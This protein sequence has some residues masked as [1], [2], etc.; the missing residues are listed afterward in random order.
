MFAT[1]HS[2]SLYG[3]IEHL[4]L[5]AKNIREF[6]H[7]ITKYILNKKIKSSKTNDFNDLKDIS[8]AA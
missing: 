4:A 5:N 8:K 1:R 7:H 3:S 6:L 2:I